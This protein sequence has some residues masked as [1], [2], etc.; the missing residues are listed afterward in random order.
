MGAAIEAMPQSV[1]PAQPFVVDACRRSCVHI[2]PTSDPGTR[3]AVRRPRPHVLPAGPP[4]ALRAAGDG[5][6]RSH[7]RAALALPRFDSLSA[8]AADETVVR[9]VYGARNGAGRGQ[10]WVRNL[11]DGVSPPSPPTTIDNV[12]T[13]H[14]WDRTSPPPTGSSTPCST[15]RATVPTMRPMCRRATRRPART[16]AMS[17]TRCSQGSDRHR[18]GVV[19]MRGAIRPSPVGRRRGQRTL[20]RPQGARRSRTRRR[21]GRGC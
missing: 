3:L 8:V 19:W 16:P 14:Q 7:A 2:W 9:V 20:R 15:T 11:P 10:V 12:A 4:A 6:D 1:P 21:H 18:A 13:E 5:P 17:S